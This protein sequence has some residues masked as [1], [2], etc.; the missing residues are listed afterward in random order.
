MSFETIP[1]LGQVVA[2]VGDYVRQLPDPSDADPAMS[3]ASESALVDNLVG[4]AA[5]QGITNEQL[6]GY[7]YVA[8]GRA[9]A[10]PDVLEAINGALRAALSNID[11]AASAA[12]QTEFRRTMT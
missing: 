6:F 2:A 3:T 12:P 1:A 11:D 8:A 5:S 10:T 7:F 4:I 9:E